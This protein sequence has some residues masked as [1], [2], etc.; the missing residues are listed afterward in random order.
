MPIFFF[1][2]FPCCT[3]CVGLYC[4]GISGWKW[5]HS[6]GNRV[7]YICT[8]GIVLIRSAWTTAHVRKK[9]ASRGK[10]RGFLDLVTKTIFW[11]PF[12]DLSVSIPRVSKWDHDQEIWTNLAPQFRL[13]MIWRVSEVL[14]IFPSWPIGGRFFEPSELHCVRIFQ[15]FF[16][17]CELDIFF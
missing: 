17:G 1:F 14:T 6:K 8:S 16:K 5:C 4:V 3:R 12:I 9:H 13:S 15:H 10:W 2:F 7:S 11:A